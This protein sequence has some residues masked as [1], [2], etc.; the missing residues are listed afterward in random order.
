MGLHGGSGRQVRPARPVGS[1]RD[2]GLDMRINFCGNCEYYADRECRRFP[3]VAV[4]VL[5]DNQTG[6]TDTAFMYPWM[7]G[8]HP[9]CG[10]FKR[11][12]DLVG[13]GLRAEREDKA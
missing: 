8:D 12:L 11:S 13:E 10:E 5:T 6:H 1:R 9:C 7:G 4:Q 3:P 2:R